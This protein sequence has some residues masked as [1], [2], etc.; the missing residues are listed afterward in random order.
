[1]N[2]SMVPSQDATCATTSVVTALAIKILH[3]QPLMVLGY[4][5][6]AGSVDA[7]AHSAQ[8][9]GRVWVCQ[10]SVSMIMSWAVFQ[11]LDLNASAYRDI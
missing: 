2:S 3:S 7:E 1:M 9:S 11:K 8:R 4:V 6:R 10:E 5:T